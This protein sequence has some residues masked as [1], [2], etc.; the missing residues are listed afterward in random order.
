[1]IFHFGW[2]FRA[3]IFRNE[4][5]WR[6]MLLVKIS[7]R[8]VAPNLVSGP[9]KGYFWLSEKLTKVLYNTCY[10]ARASFK[11]KLMLVRN[12]CPNRIFY[13]LLCKY[14]PLPILANQNFCHSQNETSTIIYHSI[15]NFMGYKM[16]LNSRGKYA[17]FK[18][19]SVSH[20]W[21]NMK[22]PF[23][24]TLCLSDKYF[25]VLKKWVQSKIG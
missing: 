5:S 7:A 2:S 18:N 9:N 16:M 25:C 24:L 1:M 12:F 3:E 13:S 19:S 11:S 23:N 10:R 8:L 4:W 15:E 21:G 22:N 17:A 20:F 14:W 6:H